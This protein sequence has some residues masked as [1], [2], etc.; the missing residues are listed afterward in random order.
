MKIQ[1]KQA[2]T[3]GLVIA[4]FLL[5]SI[6]LYFFNQFETILYSPSIKSEEWCDNQP[7]VQIELFST[8]FI[9]VQPSST[10]IVYFLGILTVLIGAY[11]LKVGRKQKF[12]AW[13]G[14]ALLLWGLGAIFA[15]TSYQAF[16]YEIKCAGRAFCIWTSWWEVMYLIF[17]VGS[18]DAMMIAQTNLTPE[19][20]HYTVM[21][22]YATI[23]FLV[24][25]LIVVIGSVIPITILISFELMVLF[26]A[27]SIMIFILFNLK[28]RRRLKQPIDLYLLRIWVFLIIIMGTYFLYFMTNVTEILWEHDIWFSANDVLHIGLILWML[29]IWFTLNKF[30]KLN[31]L[32][33]S[34]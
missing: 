2:L 27:P 3:Y 24:Y 18:V 7:C 15:G 30:K 20:T 31:D 13:W 19:R 6:L 25:V 22:L 11:L 33:K 12:V 1:R 16:S 21:R 14:I 4:I 8:V 26:L 9:V 10:F 34:Q 17:W 28:R 23:N 5:I 29:Y 32:E